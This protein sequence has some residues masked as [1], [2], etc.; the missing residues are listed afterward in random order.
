MIVLCCAV[1]ARDLQRVV[2]FP[3]Y[4]QQKGYWKHICDRL[5]GKVECHNS[6]QNILME[7]EV[8]HYMKKKDN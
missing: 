6:F 4:E 8:E 3:E 7:K 1:E 2:C 5:I